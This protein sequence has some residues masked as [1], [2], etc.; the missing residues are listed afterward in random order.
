MLRGGVLDKKVTS[1]H[2]I[3]FYRIFLP[4]TSHLQQQH[5]GRCYEYL[6]GAVS[7]MIGVI[8]SQ[9]IALS[10]NGRQ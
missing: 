2:G 3:A 9:S 7:M 8:I 1:Y 6:A 10:A 5:V 4:L